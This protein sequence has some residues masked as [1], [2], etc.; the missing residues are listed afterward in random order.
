M[1]TSGSLPV[2]DDLGIDAVGNWMGFAVGD[3]D[4]DQDLDVFVT[5]QGSNMRLHPPKEQV[6]GDCRYTDR[7][8]LGHL[9]ALPAP[10]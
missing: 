9:Y 7:F 2:A 6:G 1:A 3:Y 4:G 8:E 10:K 5:N